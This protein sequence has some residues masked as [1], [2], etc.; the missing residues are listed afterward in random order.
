MTRGFA[1]A[2]V[3]VMLLAGCASEQSS[4]AFSE[5]SHVHNVITHDDEIILATHYGPHVWTG[6]GW[7]LRGD[8]FD[9]MALSAGDGLLFASGHPGASQNLPDPLGLLVSSD[10]GETWEPRSLLGEVDFHLLSVSGSTI[11]GVAANYGVVVRSDDSGANWDTVQVPSITDLS[12]NPASGS[13]MMIASEGNLLVSRDSGATFQP[14]EGPSGVTKIE[15]SRDSV[16]VATATTV[17]LRS[18]DSAPFTALP[19]TFDQVS[20][21]AIGGQKIVVVDA[22]GV[23][24]SD[25]GGQTF[26][27]LG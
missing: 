7:E 5:L 17:F 23:S 1:L 22:G 25:N 19:H 9:V 24:V 4:L 12:V 13:E 20:H 3:A 18:S 21:I 16:L 26:S 8:D 11:V 27:R 10:G 14:I 6:S 2:G 15:W